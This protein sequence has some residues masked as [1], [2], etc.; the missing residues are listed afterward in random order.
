MTPDYP[1]VV[2]EWEDAILYQ[3]TMPYAE[4]F[5]HDPLITTTVGIEL[6]N[7]E[8][9][10]SVAFGHVDD[11]YDHI[12]TIPR[13]YVRWVHYFPTVEEIRRQESETNRSATEAKEDA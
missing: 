5:K 3:G 1:I 6:R 13:A 2:V 12:L 10:V 9:Y 7:D 4:I 11:K 8:Q